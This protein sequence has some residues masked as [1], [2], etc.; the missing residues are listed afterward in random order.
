MGKRYVHRPVG[1]AE[2][3]SLLELATAEERAFFE[4]NRTLVRPYR[5]RLLAIALCQG[6]ALQY[7]GRGY[8]VNDFDV[9]FFYAQNPAK[10]RLSRTV[11]RVFATVG[12]FDHVPVD[13][14]R[15]V[16]PSPRAGR[17]QSTAQRIR[18]FLHEGPTANARH[19]SA[20]AV[21]GLSPRT[22]FGRILWQSAPGGL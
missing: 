7:A 20:K 4:R 8:G 11:K 18:T 6:A 21:V 19:L 16:V 17:K 2:L 5:S 12:A 15:T 22:I 1:G 9:H 10:P 14:I 13:F 3:R